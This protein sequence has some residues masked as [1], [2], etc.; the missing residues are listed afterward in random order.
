MTTVELAPEINSAHPGRCVP[1]PTVSGGLPL[2]GHTIEFMR[3]PVA[4][5]ERGWREQG[6]I[7]SVRVAGRHT[8]VLLGPEH[9]KFVFAE[10]GKSLSMR[11]AYPFLAEMFSPSFYFVAEPDEYER[12]RNLVLPRFRG[13]QLG[14]YTKIMERETLAFIDRLG[15]QGEVDIVTI[16]GPLVMRIAAHAFV[17]ERFSARMEDGYFDE[18]RRFSAGIDAITPSWLP[19][20]HRVRSRRAG[21]RLRV[22]FTGL[23]RERAAEPVDPPDF[24]Q[25][26]AD[27]GRPGDDPIPESVLVNLLLG[28]TWAGHE[29]TVGQLAWALIEIL[30]RPDE[31][32]RLLDE[33]R[34]L[35][36][37]DAPLTPAGIR[38]LSHLDRFLREVERANPVAAL[39]PRVAEQ[40]VD[41]DGYRIPAGSWV[42][43]APAIS[44]RLPE[45][46]PHPDRF[47]PDRYL[48]NPRSVND[49][50]GF[51]GGMHRCLGLHFAYLEMKI[52]IIRLLQRFELELVGDAPQPVRGLKARW[53]TS[54]CRVRYRRRVY[55]PI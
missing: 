14:T 31:L 40:T 48:E 37:G 13:H 45:V 28:L 22:A 18:F 53:P 26:L 52:V 3:D 1:P 6:R 27:A 23:L 17:G 46:F 4:L 35:V 36:D 55:A 42:F 20:P 15:D 33:Q 49:L 10:T 16:L 51:G 38:Q 9:N 47:R 43:L 11:A 50:I 44:H 41:H 34:D 54:P 29:T 25:A 39:I 2:L 7:F 5:F 24:L 19:L 30:R 32:R 12:Q 21:K 8:V